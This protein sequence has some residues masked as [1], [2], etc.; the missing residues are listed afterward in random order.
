MLYKYFSF[1]LHILFWLC[2]IAIPEINNSL[3]EN[4]FLHELT[5]LALIPLSKKT[6]KHLTSSSHS[7]C[8]F[9]SYCLLFDM[10]FLK[11]PSFPLSC[12]WRSSIIRSSSPSSNIHISFLSISHSRAILLCP[13][14]QDK[15][16][17]VNNSA[18]TGFRKN[19]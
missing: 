5:S 15:L 17:P 11:L 4:T 8:Y 7:L 10:V 12:H 3:R 16:S 13:V 1:T 9:L 6:F 19:I 14:T 2:N 18:N